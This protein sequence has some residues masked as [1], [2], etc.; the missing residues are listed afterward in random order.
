[1]LY[2]SADH[3][4][5]RYPSVYLSVRPSV[6]RLYCIETAKHIIKLFHLRVATPFWFFHTKRF[7]NIPNGSVERKG[8]EKIEILDQY[9]ALSR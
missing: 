2:V 7:G 1:M 9:L 4:V 5:A 8:Y 6:R 3:A